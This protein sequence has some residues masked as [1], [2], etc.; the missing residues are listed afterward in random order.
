[1]RLKNKIAV[2]TGGGTGI[3]KAVAELFAREGALVS[4][5]DLNGA[6]KTVQTI[7]QTGGTGIPFTMDIA[8][9]S[10]VKSAVSILV[11]KYKQ[12]DI[13]VNCAGLCNATP[14]Y[15]MTEKEWN[16]VNR[17]N[18]WG[19]FCCCRA[20]IEAMQQK[21]EGSIINLTSQSAKTG[22]TFAGMHYVA[23]KA[24]IVSMTYSM[25]KLFAKDHIRVNGIAPGIIETDMIKTITKGN[26]NAYD[27]AIPLGRIGTAKEVSYSALFLASEESSYITGEI[28]DVNGGQFMD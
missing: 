22:G 25:A 9:E 28:I 23:S 8:D 21:K 3:G 26:M 14:F 5:W 16:K 7:Q 17:V 11:E 24:A 27:D 4:V 10:A 2:V 6:E 15:E 19:T 20:V 1:M 18:V 13:L 12:I